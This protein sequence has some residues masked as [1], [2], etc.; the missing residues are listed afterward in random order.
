M[1]V[2][3]NIHRRVARKHIRI[4]N[5]SYNFYNIQ[6]VFYFFLTIYDYDYT[7]YINNL[8][9]TKLIFNNPKKIKYF[10]RRKKY[11]YIC[12]YRFL[13]VS[14]LQLF[15]YLV[16]NDYI[17]LNVKARTFA[18]TPRFGH[19]DDDNR[20]DCLLRVAAMKH[21]RKK[22]QP[23][24]INVKLKRARDPHPFLFISSLKCAVAVVHILVIILRYSSADNAALDWANVGFSPAPEQTAT[25]N[26]DNCT[27]H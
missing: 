16:N 15:M 8:T 24:N 27:R 20:I 10:I 4:L 2:L 7:T 26:V 11:I 9:D 21:I 13:Y 5:V 25:G 23:L 19:Y 17:F 22:T 18:Q 6:Y 1:F 14:L 3:Q 12:N